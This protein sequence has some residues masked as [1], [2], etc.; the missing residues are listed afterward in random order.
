MSGAVEAAIPADVLRNLDHP[1]VKR[2][3]LRPMLCPSCFRQVQTWA[4]IQ[5]C[6]SAVQPPRLTTEDGKQ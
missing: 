4:H 6:R 1:M 2:R 3:M 5:G